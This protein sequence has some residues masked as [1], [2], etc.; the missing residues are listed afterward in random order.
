MARSPIPT[1]C[2]AVVLVK[3]GDRF[4]LVHERK[5]DQLWYLPAGRVEPGETFAEAACRE[6]LEETGVPVKLQG[7]LRI[8][9]SPSALQARMRVIFLARP[10]DDTPP[11][12]EPDKHS[13]EAR[14][15]ALKELRALPLRGPDVEPLCRGVLAGAPVFPLSLLGP[16]GE[17]LL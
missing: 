16:E 8:E 3:L 4:L 1:W 2:F 17:P 12:R 9:H 5:H 6:A 10:A 14:W 11:K 7:I 15:V 13:L